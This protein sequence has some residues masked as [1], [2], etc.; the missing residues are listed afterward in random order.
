VVAINRRVCCE[1]L[2]SKQI[3]VTLQDIGLSA[4]AEI[5]QQSIE[6][7]PPLSQSFIQ[8]LKFARN[9]IECALNYLSRF[10][11]FHLKT[12]SE[13]ASLEGQKV[14]FGTSAAAVV[15]IVG[16]ILKFHGV[17]ILS[18]KGREIVFKLACIAHFQAQGNIGSGFDVAASTWGGIFVYKRFNPIW[19]E[20]QLKES[21]PLPRIIQKKWPCLLTE[22]LSLLPH[23]HMLV[24]WTGS[25]ASTEKMVQEVSHQPDR[26]VIY[27][28]IRELVIK[29]I[30][31][32]KG[33]NPQDILTLIRQ[34]ELLL[35]ELGRETGVL[36]ETPA[37]RNLANVANQ[38]GAAGKLSGAGGGDCGIALYFDSNITHALK[39]SWQ[40]LGIQIIDVRID[41]QGII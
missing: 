39:K 7:I 38:S 30:T 33:N 34:N 12:W 3:S 35:R 25:P 17:D 41:Q 31:A 9:A 20:S 22:R 23:F 16:A 14:G 4:S 40:A 26:I 28:K 18:E 36:I 6:W 24:G 13:P 11:T 10:N 32:W 29:L 15:A 19:L 27:D 8:S 37:L 2:E 1:I 21:I 5:H